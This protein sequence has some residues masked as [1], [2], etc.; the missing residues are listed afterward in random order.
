LLLLMV[1][2]ERLEHSSHVS[3]TMGTR[4]GNEVRGSTLSSCKERQGYTSLD[5]PIGSGD[6]TQ[7]VS[8]R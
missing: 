1:H 8:G 5:R 2:G 3:G 7:A 4:N 6:A